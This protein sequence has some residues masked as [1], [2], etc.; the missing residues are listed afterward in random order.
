M[1]KVHGGS[2]ARRSLIAVTAAGAL[3]IT[4]GC[5]GGGLEPIADSPYADYT[6]QLSASGASFPDAFYQVAIEEFARWA[7]DLVIDYNSTG[8]GTGKQEFSGGLTAFAG[9]DSLVG[10]GDNLDASDFY[11]LPTVAA[12]IAVSF[13]LPGIDQVQLRQETLADIFQG[14]ITTWD[15]PAIAADNPELDLPDTPITIVHRAD[16][17]GTTGNYTRF[18]H[19]AADNW[20]LGAGDAI[21]WPT[22]A[23]GGDRNTGVAQLVEHSEGAIGYIDYADTRHLNLPTAAIENAEGNFVAPSLEGATAALAGATVEDDLSYNPLNAAGADAYPITSPTY[24][25]VRPDYSHNPEQ[26]KNTHTFLTWLLTEGQDLAAEEHYAA[27]PESLREL[28]LQQ[29]DRVEW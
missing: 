3:A 19:E 5:G 18:L 22:R 11:Y 21:E 16:G 12:P 26:G 28:A 25:L 17:S 6:G 2:T 27:L 29:L 8:S 10:E 15:D 24:L 1:N 4:A 13:N 14:D 20:R 7:P 23:Q 9:T